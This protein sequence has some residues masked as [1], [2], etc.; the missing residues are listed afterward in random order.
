MKK[1][2]MF[3]LFFLS[4]YLAQAQ[5]VLGGKLNFQS[6][7]N[8]NEQLTIS[9]S[10]NSS[11]SFT[12]RLGYQFGHIWAGL[13]VGF[14][15]TKETGVNPFTNNLT[16]Y[17]SNAFLVG[18]FVRYIWKPNTYM[19]VFTEAQMYGQ[20]G[21]DFQESKKIS[22]FNQFDGLLRPG[23]MFYLGKHFILE[24]SFGNLG[25][26]RSSIKLENSTAKIKDSSFA[27]NLNSDTFLLGI[28]WLFGAAS[29]TPK[30]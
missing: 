28:N 27:F 4:A 18:P 17:N 19:G 26:Q 22:S 11:F 29:S 30:N 25:F 14:L 21:K 7:S 13:D 24:G 1:C 2:L 12:P 10:S 20:F 5:F 3:F 9:E 23:I 6:T 8:K 15:T 16:K